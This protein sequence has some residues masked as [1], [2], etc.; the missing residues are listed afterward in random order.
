[1]EQAGGSLHE[2]AIYIA[3]SQAMAFGDLLDGVHTRGSGGEECFK[4]GAQARFVEFRGRRLADQ[5]RDFA[6]DRLPG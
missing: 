6:F 1:M 5:E 4:F 3:F 2:E